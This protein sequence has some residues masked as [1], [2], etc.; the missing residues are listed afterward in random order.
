MAEG[1]MLKKNISDSRRLAELKTDSARLLWTWILPYLDVEGRYYADPELVRG[2][3]VPRL[4]SFTTA[5]IWE[6][7]QDMHRV[8]LITLYEADGEKYL[9]FRNFHEFQNLRPGRESGSKIPPPGELPEN[10]GSDPGVIPEYSH[11]REVKLREVNIREEK[12]GVGGNDRRKSDQAANSKTRFLEFVFLTQEEHQK[13]INQFGENKT[14]EKIEALNL[15]LGSN[16]K[17]Y[18]SHYHTILNWDRMEKEKK[19]LKPREPSGPPLKGPPEYDPVPEE[20]RA[21]VLQNMKKFNKTFLANFGKFQSDKE[22][23]RNDQDRN[24]GSGQGG[25]GIEGQVSP[26]DCQGPGV[27]PQ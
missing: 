12:G 21:K 13:L 9:Q 23:Q 22:G 3:V 2:K 25:Q 7:L 8:G 17:K 18:K 1:R 14:R 4:K 5:K 26:G 10:S 24:P 11:E 15:Y 6:Y 20:E 27:E 19:S 16:G